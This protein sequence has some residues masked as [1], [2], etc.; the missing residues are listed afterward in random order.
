MLMKICSGA[1]PVQKPAIL[2]ITKPKLC[3]EVKTM[4]EFFTGSSGMKRLG[5]LGIERGIERDRTLIIDAALRR[6]AAVCETA[7]RE[8][9]SHYIIHPPI[10]ARGQDHGCFSVRWLKVDRG[11]IHPSAWRSAT[12]PSTCNCVTVGHFCSHFKV[13]G[14]LQIRCESTFPKTFQDFNK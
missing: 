8:S 14:H 6:I 3:Y 10:A 5:R 4:N 1:R 12:G 11:S 13:A 7:N 2:L 9:G